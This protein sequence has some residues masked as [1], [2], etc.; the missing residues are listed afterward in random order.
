[1]CPTYEWTCTSCEHEWDVI[2]AVKDRDEPSR[3][4]KCDAQGH[5]SGVVRTNIDKSAAG[6]WNDQEYN[7]GLGCVTYGKKDRERK[8][9]ALGLEEI[10]NEKVETI[11]KTFDKR[12]QETR[13]QRWKD[14]DRVKLYDD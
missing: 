1:M 9:K 12:R 10:G 2:C 13:E 5:R 6:A 8:A 7:P 4:S 14:A 11:H 3:C